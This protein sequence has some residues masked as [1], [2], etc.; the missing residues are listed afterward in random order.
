MT[1]G[2]AMEP[3]VYAEIVSRLVSLRTLAAE[4]ADAH[5]DP[6]VKAGAEEMGISVERVLQLLGHRQ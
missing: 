4:L 1:E 6:V 2:L 3:E 5:D